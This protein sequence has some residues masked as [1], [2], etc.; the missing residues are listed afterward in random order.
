V[1]FTDDA[2]RIFNAAVKMVATGNPMNLLMVGPSG[3]GKTTMPKAIAKREGMNFLRVNCA[4]VRDP[5]EWF[6][7]R[8]AK[9]GS[10][11]FVPTE[12]TNAV[13]EGNAI[14]VLDE[15][16]RVEPWLHNTLYPLL[17]DDKSTVVHG[18][19]ITCG[20]NV[21]FVATI[22]DGSQF[23]GTFTLDTAIVNRMDAILPVRPLPFAA[24]VTLIRNRMGC[25]G[26]VY[27]NLVKMMGKVRQVI[28]K[29]DINVDASTRSTLKIARL[30]C[31]GMTPRQAI[32]YAFVNAVP[33]ENAK[34][35]IDTISSFFGS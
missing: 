16:N 2:I 5:E 35:V 28:E 17:D 19:R 34:E 8:E 32:D 31:A 27:E 4:A 30:I 23:T 1:Y 33:Q 15:F 12:F 26:P 14:I 20:P 29:H 13:R 10:T 3:Y 18:E 11:V 24:E 25:T 6:G 21:L 9:E 7:Y 22:N